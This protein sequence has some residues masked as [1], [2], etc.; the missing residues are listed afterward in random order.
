M[1]GKVIEPSTTAKLLGVNSDHE[2]RWK[3]H[4]QQVVKRATQVNIALGGLR[5]LRRL[6]EAWV[7]PVLDYASTLWHDPLRDKTHPRH[8]RTVQRAALIRV[9]SAFQTVATST[10]DVE[11]H[12]L[13]TI[14]ASDTVHRLTPTGCTPCRETILSEICCHAHTGEGIIL[15]RTPGSHSRKL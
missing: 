15:D 7:T 13:P 12:V 11:A 1:N 8:L 9:L 4:V 6:Y 10:L 5:Q 14:F 2:L 3:D